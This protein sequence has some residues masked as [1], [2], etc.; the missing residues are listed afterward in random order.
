MGI[1]IPFDFHIFQ[2]GFV[3]HQPDNCDPSSPELQLKKMPGPPPLLAP[4]MWRPESRSRGTYGF[5]VRTSRFWPINIIY[6]TLRKL[7][8]KQTS[9]FGLSNKLPCSLA[10]TRTSGRSGCW[11]SHGC[12]FMVSEGK[13][14]VRA[15]RMPS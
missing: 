2:R 12:R 4:V 9:R 6:I 8:R 5:D 10:A 11:G 7:L 15:P 13:E 14:F 3:N 1:I